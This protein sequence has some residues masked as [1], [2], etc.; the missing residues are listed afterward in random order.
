[1]RHELTRGDLKKLMRE[2]ARSA[3]RGRKFRVYF[4]GGGTAVQS[5][6]RPS[7]I[8][9]DVYSDDD[10]VFRDV[11]G[12]KERL[13]LNIEF[14]RPED[15]VPAL[16]ASDKRHVL[17]DTVGGVS[18]FHY[19]PYAQLLSKLARGF[20]KDMSDADNFVASGMVDV[21]R[22]RRLV[23]EIPDEAFARYPALSRK[24]VREVVEEFTS[25]RR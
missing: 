21:A 1:M 5:G 8:D 19:D 15:F 11:Q 20:N 9:A 17:I 25:R 18:F 4:I 14:A 10:D 24:A 7:T 16:A 2:I 22:F 6:W 12:I 23:D 13:R 3:P